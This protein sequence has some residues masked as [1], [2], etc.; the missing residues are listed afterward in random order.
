MKKLLLGACIIFIGIFSAKAQLPYAQNFETTMTA[1]PVGWD[2]GYFTHHPGNPG[3]MF[4]NTYPSHGNSLWQYYYTAHTYVAYVDDIDYDYTGGSWNNTSAVTCYDTVA[5]ANFSCTGD[6]SVFV[7]FDMNFNN[8]TGGGEKGTIA[9]STNGGATWTTAATLPVLSGDV[10]WHNGQLYDISALAGGHATVKVAFC[11]NNAAAVAG[12]HCGWGMAIDNVNIYAPPAYDAK[13]LSSTI[14]SSKYYGKGTTNPVTATLQN[15][16]GTALTSLTINWKCTDGNS[17][18]S[19]GAVSIAPIQTGSATCGTSWTPTVSGVYNMKIWA[20]QLNGSNLNQ[21]PNDTLY[22]NGIN[23]IDSI[24]AKTV[25]FEEFNQASCDP[26]ADA[27]PNIDSV[28]ATNA[29]IIDPV[30][31]HVNWPGTDYMNDETQTPFIGARVSYY[32]VN[33]V[34]DGKLDG[35]DIYPGDGY[36]NSPQVQSEAAAGSPFKITITSAVY[37]P[38]TN[39][40]TVTA[41][42]K[43]YAAFSAGL[44]AGAYISVDTINYAANQ[45][46]E[47]IPQYNFPQVAEDMMP[48]A[49]GTTLAAFTTGQTQTLSLSWTKNHPWGLAP[50][51]HTYDSTGC[52][53]TIFVQNNST[54]YVYQC[55]A[56]HFSTPTGVENI[57]N[58][59][60]FDVYPNP[61]NSDATIAFSLVK[62]QN[63]VVEV[64]NTLGQDVYTQNAGTMGSGEHLI[65]I[66]G[67]GLKS[68][69][70][71]IKVTTDN[72]TSIQKLVIQK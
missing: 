20:T 40:F 50:H 29:A 35:M 71:F 45:S 41:N 43:A 36:F 8:Y 4:N 72:A 27:K 26:C 69:V 2:T 65:T 67:N 48:S 66:P 51:T 32:S 34:P 33:S 19:A 1:M 9:V 23:V 37:N 6:P 24:Q 3:W 54:Q 47:S 5:T 11:W 64:Y 16:G 28:C 44:S 62:D 58:G 55:A 38:A 57:A 42:I 53:V 14:L 31:L 18:T 7:G 59:V 68:G 21:D 61:T 39:K 13:V 52:G 12:G 46:T 60:S 56:A 22:I 10:S 15:L 25:L 63:V 70:Y 17:G 49:S 30:R